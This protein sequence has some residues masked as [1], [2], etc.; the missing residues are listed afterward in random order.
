MT[1]RLLLCDDQD[2]VTEGMGVILRTVRDF[3][4]VGVAHDGAEAVELVAETQP[5]VVL[6]DLR[7]PVMNGIQAT[8]KIRERFPQT[9]VL[10]LTTYDDDEWV[11]DAI[12]AGAAGYL[13]KDTGREQIIAAIRGTAEGATFVDPQVAGKLF[14]HIAQGNTSTMGSR[15]TLAVDLSERERE[16]LRLLADGLPNGEIAER[17]HLS[18]GTVQNYV[19]S[20]L[21]KLDVTDRT[22]AAVI[23]LKHG[24][25]GE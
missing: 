10:V 3:A 8:R 11:F 13:L 25:V 23:A 19:S 15:S 5:D 16:I 9:R 6:M 14:A 22:Q 12:R 2:I 18:K 21:L 1:I 7:M 17:L 24:L 4:V 20:I